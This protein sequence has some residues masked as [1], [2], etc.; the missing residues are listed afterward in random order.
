MATPFKAVAV[1]GGA[2]SEEQFA[3][4]H[5]DHFALT[6]LLKKLLESTPGSRVV[7]RSSSASDFCKVLDLNG[8]A[9]VNKEAFSMLD[10]YQQGGIQHV[11]HLLL[12]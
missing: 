12:L 1:A 10:T 11:G 5:L 4:N 7:N 3:V 8:Y 2:M 9:G 6:G